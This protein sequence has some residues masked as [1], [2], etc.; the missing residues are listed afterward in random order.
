MDRLNF[1]LATG[2][3]DCVLIIDDSP[4]DSWLACKIFEVSNIC[5]SVLT[6]ST[7]EKGLKIIDDYFKIHQRLPDIILVDF[8]MPLM[9]GLEVIKNIKGNPAYL[10]EETEIILISAGLDEADLQK[11]GDMGIKNILLKPL[12][13]TELLEI[14]SPENKC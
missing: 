11:M 3:F 6:A 8:Q 5:R 4:I 2:K 1:K 7:G 9:D 13:K 12:D 10:K 14:L